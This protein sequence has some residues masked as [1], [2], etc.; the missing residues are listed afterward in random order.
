MTSFAGL[1]KRGAV[2]EN[3]HNR[4]VSS[5]EKMR[6]NMPHEAMADNRSYI[7]RPPPR[8]PRT[9]LK[10]AFWVYLSPGNLLLHGLRPGDICQIQSLQGTSRLAI[11]RDNS[12]IQDSVCQ[13]SPTIQAIYGF[14]LGD[15]VSIQASKES[16]ATAGS[17]NL[18]EH[19]NETIAIRDR[20][21]W[22]WV[23]E[24]ALRRAEYLCPG[25]VFEVEARYQRKSFIVTSVNGSSKVAV[26]RLNPGS[27]VTV[28]VDAIGSQSEVSS[29]SG[30][31]SLEILNEQIAG[32]DR[33]IMEINYWLTDCSDSPHDKVKFPAHLPFLWGGLLIHGPSGTGKTLILDHVTKIGGIRAFRLEMTG[34]GQ[35]ENEKNLRQTFAEA[36]CHQPSVIVIDRLEDMC[37]KLQ[38]Q[39][40]LPSLDLTSVLCAEID[41]SSAT[42]TLIIAATRSLGSIN[43]DLIESGRF[44]IEVETT[45]PDSKARIEILKII[46]GLSK[47]AESP[48]LHHIGERTH[49]YV[50]ADLRRLF[51][52]AMD[53]ARKRDLGLRSKNATIKTNGVANI[54]KETTVTESDLNAALL[55]IRP[56]VMREVFLETPNVRW[57]DIGGQEEVKNSLQKAVEWPFK[58]CAPSARVRCP[59]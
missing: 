37:G 15:H 39:A 3:S 54:E 24:D 45:V 33:Q 56:R 6:T 28:D 27:D 26:F 7:V 22:A 23:A 16:I 10:D 18:R 46:S 17:V 9:D 44:R 1:G 25:M 58:V 38:P 13:V 48:E 20:P 50:G 57:S 34:K 42:R 51:K 2:S 53:K 41:G 29:S 31:G 4:N 35:A 36:R 19:A 49:G 11:A 12:K 30:H 8:A 5:L 52:R 21:H 14:K 40:S 59:S 55:E 43:D 47:D 32:L